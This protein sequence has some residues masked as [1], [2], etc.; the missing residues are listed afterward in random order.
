[1]SNE[2]KVR[3]DSWDR[4]DEAAD[5]SFPASDPSAGTLGRDRPVALGSFPTSDSRTQV[6]GI[7]SDQSAATRAIE[8]LVEAHF[9]AE[10]DIRIIVA[11]HRHR[12]E[13]HMTLMS[14]LR[15]GAPLG[16]GIGLAAGAVFATLVSLGVIGGPA[17]LAGDAPWI[18]ALKGA[19][20]GAAAGYLVGTLAGL[21]FWK[22]KAGFQAEDAHPGAIWLGVRATGAR[23]QEARAI[24]RKAGARHFQG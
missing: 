4:V 21:G 8:G 1:M 9:D 3:A 11:H 2:S 22:D 20:V 19:P 14:G 18:A 12:H 16:A 15:L 6:A 17:M 24:M 7:F 23:T 10:R 5:E 13:V